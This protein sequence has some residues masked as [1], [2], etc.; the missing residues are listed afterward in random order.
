MFDFFYFKSQIISFLKQSGYG[1]EIKKPKDNR[2]FL[3][4]DLDF[5][6]IANGKNTG[7]IGEVD[8]NVLSYYKISKPVFICQMDL[9]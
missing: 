3:R 6:L 1:I 2:E 9:G 7:I 4:N 5:D 8:K